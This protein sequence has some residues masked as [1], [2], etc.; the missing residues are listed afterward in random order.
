MEHRIQQL[1]FKLAEQELKLAAQ[2]Q[3]NVALREDI[4]SLKEIQNG[5]RGECQAGFEHLEGKNKKTY[6]LLGEANSSII[7]LQD[8]QVR[9]ATKAELRYVYTGLSFTGLG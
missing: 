8:Q 6:A 3:T 2:E 4:K 7:A 9:L 5:D 1:E